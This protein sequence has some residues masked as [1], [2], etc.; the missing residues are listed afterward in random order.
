MTR[1]LDTRQ[2]R[3][4]L[5][6]LKNQ[7]CNIQEDKEAGTAS[8]SFDGATVLNALQAGRGNRWIVRY[9]NSK[10]YKWNE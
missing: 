2:V 6:H 3:H 8:A 5:I 1:F 10:D 9:I 7:G 4:I